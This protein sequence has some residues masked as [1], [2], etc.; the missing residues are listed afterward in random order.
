MKNKIIFLGPGAHNMKIIFDFDH[1]SD[2]IVPCVLQQFVNHDGILVKAYLLGE[3][4]HNN[5]TNFRIVYRSSIKNLSK[6]TSKKTVSF[7][8]NDIAHSPLANKNKIEHNDLRIDE[9]KIKD[10]CNSIQKK[11]KLNLLGI[12][13]IIDSQTQQ[14]A[15]IDVNYFPGYSAL[16]HLN[17]QLLNLC[18]KLYEQSTK[19]RY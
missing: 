18:L 13:I 9:I 1:L 8:T 16:D 10:I 15:V 3:I 11:L 12:D 7:T 19:E 4:L 6:L 17:E 14:Y 2:I 5:N